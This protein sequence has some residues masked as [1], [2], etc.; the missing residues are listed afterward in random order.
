[1]ART[2]LIVEDDRALAGTLEIG[3]LALDDVDTVTVFDGREAMEPAPDS[4]QNRRVLDDALDLARWQ[5]IE[6]E[7]APDADAERSTGE[8][9]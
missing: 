8:R 7:H 5:R 3:L 9:T 1:M 4:G 6:A 2:I